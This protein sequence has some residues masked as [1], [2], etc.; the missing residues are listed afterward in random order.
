MKPESAPPVQ[1]NEEEVGTNA[2]KR[3]QEP[4]LDFLVRFSEFRPAL[5]AYQSALR[6]DGWDTLQSLRLFL[7]VDMARL[8][9]LP[10]H[11]RLL[12]DTLKDL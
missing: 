1:R 7:A 11:R 5:A 2:V 4:E 8:N 9:I 12:V 6:C 3:V 10:G